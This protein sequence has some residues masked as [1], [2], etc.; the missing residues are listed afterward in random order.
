MWEKA[1]KELAFLRGGKHC[2]D[3]ML[4]LSLQPYRVA[5]D[6]SILREKAQ[7]VLKKATTEEGLK[8]VL[9]LEALSREVKKGLLPQKNPG[10][11]MSLFQANLKRQ[12]V[13]KKRLDRGF[14]DFIG[15]RKGLKGLLQKWYFDSAEMH[16]EAE[17]DLVH[18]LYES[19][20]YHL[21]V[22][23][24]DALLVEVASGEPKRVDFSEAVGYG[25]PI[26]EM[27]IE[28]KVSQ[29]KRLVKSL[30]TPLKK[31]DPDSLVE[32]FFGYVSFQRKRGVAYYYT[33]AD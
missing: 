17:H 18:H 14:P 1:G 32:D 8:E 16:L 21:L 24:H 23:L 15:P 5:I 4:H 10:K 22:S 28:K 12:G 31:L 11:I 13:R 6:S 26:C 19:E 29:M 20:R 9:G 7:E 33:E 27:M 2:R 30:G 25:N 3:E